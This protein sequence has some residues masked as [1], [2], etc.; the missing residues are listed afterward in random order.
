MSRGIKMIGMIAGLFLG[1]LFAAVTRKYMLVIIKVIVLIFIKM[2]LRHFDS[3]QINFVSYC[4]M[5]PKTR[6]SLG[7]I[8]V[9][10]TSYWFEI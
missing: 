2:S 7:F 8:S 6:L 10:D 4:F 9:E 3:L 5:I 1:A